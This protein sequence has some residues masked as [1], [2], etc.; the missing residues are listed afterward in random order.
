MTA[1]SRLLPNGAVEIGCHMEHFLNAVT[2]ALFDL[3]TTRAISTA[4][5]DTSVPLTGTK[6]FD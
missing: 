6:I 1:N 5:R 4:R 2:R 3:A